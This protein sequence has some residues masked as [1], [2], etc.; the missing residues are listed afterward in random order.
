MPKS[1]WF[2]IIGMLVNVTGA[3]F[4]WPLNTIYINEHLGKSLSV[5]G[6]V[7]MLNSAAS[8]VGN[9]LG[10]TLFDK[11]GGYK[12]IL[13]GIIITLIALVGLVFFHGWPTYVVLLVVVGFGSGIVF[14]SMYAMAGSVWPQGGRKAF[15]A[16]YVAQ[17]AGV[18]IGAAV[19]GIVASYSFTYIFLANTIL[20]VIFLLIAIFSYR[21]ISVTVG[22]TNVL[23][24]AGALGIKRS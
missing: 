2:L 11:I 20:Y 4:L 12:S 3:S 16:M 22:Q 17:N 18:A 5:A 13:S 1:L 21:H 14:P 7:L 24:E 9:L 6:V 8:V 15:N 19:G 23:N 10:G